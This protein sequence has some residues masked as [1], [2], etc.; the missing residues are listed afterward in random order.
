MAARYIA[1][2]EDRFLALYPHKMS[3]DL[4]YLAGKLRAAQARGNVE[5]LEISPALLARKD[6]F[7]REQANEAEAIEAYLQRIKD[8]YAGKRVFAMSLPHTM[9]QTAESS[10]DQIPRGLFSSDSV[11]F[12]PGGTKGQSLPDNW[13]ESVKEM[14]GV[15]YITNAYGMSEVIGL[16]PIC[17]HGH[18]HLVPWVIPFVLDPDTC[19]PLP[20]TGVQTGRAAFFDLGVSNHW[21]GFISGDEITVHWDDRCPCGMKGAFMKD[22]VVRYSE[23]QG[24]DDKINCVATASAHQDALDFLLEG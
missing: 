4:M 13:M 10:R 22:D 20:R 17:E 9:Y 21:G 7:A 3:A 6:E 19:A 15:E 2:A 12:C 1:G 16:N 11:M 5:D 14:T 8:E 23:K 18:Y 24:G